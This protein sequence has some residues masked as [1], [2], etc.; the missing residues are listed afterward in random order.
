MYSCYGCRWSGQSRLW[1]S[2]WGSCLRSLFYLWIRRTKTSKHRFTSLCNILIT[3]ACLCEHEAK[4]HTTPRT[5][6]DGWLLSALLLF[7]CF[8]RGSV[9]VDERLMNTTL[10]MIKRDEQISWSQ[11]HFSVCC[12]SLSLCNWAAIFRWWLFAIRFIFCQVLTRCKHKGLEQTFELCYIYMY[13]CQLRRNLTNYTPLH[14]TN[15]HRAS[16]QSPHRCVSPDMWEEN[17]C[18]PGLD[19]LL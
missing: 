1:Q 6:T 9:N 7:Y 10:M 18:N 8:N 14:L 5:N 12:F 19:Y 2:S 13:V 17:I 3:L 11:K 16:C 15:T 4:S